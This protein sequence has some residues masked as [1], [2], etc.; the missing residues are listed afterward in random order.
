MQVL[1]Q[2]F[3]IEFPTNPEVMNQMLLNVERAARL[4]YKTEGKMGEEFNSNF[5]RKKV[6][7]GHLSVVEHSL[8]TFDITCDRGVSHEL[9]RH[10]IGM[11]FSQE[12]TRYCNYGNG[13]FGG[14]VTFIK[15][16]FYTEG[17]NEYN[18]WYNTCLASEIGYLKLIAMGSSPQEARSILV[19]SLKTQLKMSGNFRSLR[20]FFKLRCAKTAHPQM[21][22][23]AIP[24]LWKCTELAP[25]MFEDIEYDKEF[26]EKYLLK[27]S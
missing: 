2:G 8:I 17:T 6:D 9:V 21:R 25:V 26:A 20:H 12:S 16:L 18:V 3:N 1:E 10:R 19:N 13:E 14:K 11:S 23:L 22:E 15:P 5:L 24:M 4:C 7:A 27:V